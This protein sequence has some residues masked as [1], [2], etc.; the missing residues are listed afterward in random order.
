MIVHVCTV[1]ASGQIDVWYYD[2]IN[3]LASKVILLAHSLHTMQP[4]EGTPSQEKGSNM[5]TP[6]AVALT[7]WRSST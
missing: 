6:A 4:D 5:K 1:I 2:R 7:P 3:D